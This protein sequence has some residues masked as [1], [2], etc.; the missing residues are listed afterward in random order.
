MK[1]T[2]LLFAEALSLWTWMFL[3]FGGVVDSWAPER[4]SRETTAREHGKRVGASA[5]VP[6]HGWQTLAI[7][8]INNATRTWRERRTT[9]RDARATLQKIK[10]M[11]SS[12]SIE[13]TCYG[14]DFI[15]IENCT[16]HE[17]CRTCGY[18]ANPDGRDECIE[19][20]VGYKEHKDEYNGSRYC[21]SVTV[22]P[23]PINPNGSEK[24]FENEGDT[25][26]IT[27]CRC[28][29][30]CA[31][32]GYSNFPV[33]DKDCITCPN[34]EDA[35]P[36]FSDGRGYCEFTPMNVSESN[37]CVYLRKD[38]ECTAK[39]NLNDC[40]SLNYCE[41]QKTP[42]VGCRI[43]GIYDNT[44]DEHFDDQSYWDRL[45]EIAWS[46]CPQV[47]SHDHGHHYHSLVAK[48]E[49]NRLPGCKFDSERDGEGNIKEYCTLSNSGIYDL[50]GD[51]MVA[52]SVIEAI[53]CE[54]LSDFQENCTEN[55]ACTSEN[56]SVYDYWSGQSN[57]TVCYLREDWWEWQGQGN[58]YDSICSPETDIMTV[59]MDTTADFPCNLRHTYFLCDLIEDEEACNSPLNANCEWF[60]GQGCSWSTNI[61]LQMSRV[62]QTLDFLSFET[63]LSCS[64]IG[65]SNSS[66]C[67]EALDCEYVSQSESFTTTLGSCIPTLPAVTATMPN[68]DMM[69]STWVYKGNRCKLFSNSKMGCE[70]AADD[71]C[72]FQ[73][74]WRNTDTDD[75]GDWYKYTSCRAQG[76]RWDS[77]N[78]QTNCPSFDWTIPSPPPS[79]PPPPPYPPLRD[80]VVYVLRKFNNHTWPKNK[81]AAEELC[82]KEGGILASI[83][84]PIE[85]TAV[86][87]LLRNQQY[88]MYWIGA[89]DERDEGTW[90]WSDGSPLTYNF[91]ANDGYGWYDEPNGG[92]WENCAATTPDGWYDISCDSELLDVIC[93]VPTPPPSPSFLSTSYA[94]PQFHLELLPLFAAFFMAMPVL[95]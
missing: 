6:H 36:V 73:E 1:S 21:I 44:W 39:S 48:T 60:Y 51:K 78:E 18:N 5:T 70:Q 13:T 19:C 65:A 77:F 30:S 10:Q 72:Y 42:G 27:G 33:T 88:S 63:A 74:V 82:V 25:T 71:W 75:G 62:S 92:T 80:D 57:R 67:N 81:D 66:A 4:A 54:K 56:I 31:T 12:G 41:W 59:E 3:C 35:T 87:T 14:A 61:S 8:K 91:W 9:E 76:D 43:H 29:E 11:Y 90:L 45:E 47:H 26:T 55:P 16:C 49:C 28:H 86:D 85:Q 79:S 64:A 53:N 7:R 83:K 2:T 34:G 94:A 15:R 58:G 24:C 17:S 38:R 32:C 20:A 89:S 37:A 84:S 95:V 69:A 40:S 68:N 46:T 52:F 22:S 93:Q 50:Y 23:F